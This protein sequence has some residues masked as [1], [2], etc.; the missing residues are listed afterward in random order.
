MVEPMRHY[1]LKHF[2]ET[3]S[4]S[5]LTVNVKLPMLHC[6]ATRQFTPRY[7]QLT[8]A[9]VPIG[10]IVW[11]SNTRLCSRASGSLLAKIASDARFIVP[12][13]YNVIQ[14]SGTK[15]IAKEYSPRT[16]SYDLFLG[17][18]KYI[19]LFHRLLKAGY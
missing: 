2:N 3:E 7:I 15:H 9:A 10:W 13:R 17:Y 8:I 12:S 11:R 6:L 1:I 18:L 4:W 16:A 19:S 14:K 5:L